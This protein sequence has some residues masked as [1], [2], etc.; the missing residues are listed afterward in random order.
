LI[1]IYVGVSEFGPKPRDSEWAMIFQVVA[2][3]MIVLTFCLSVVYQ[4]FGFSNKKAA[5]LDK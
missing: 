1:A 5:I 3:K 4:T 2:Q